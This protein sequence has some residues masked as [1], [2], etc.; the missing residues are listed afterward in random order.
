MKKI[1]TGLCLIALGGCY[2]I[3]RT[4]PADSYLVDT[5][6]GLMCHVTECYYLDLIGSS[7]D[8]LTVAKAYGLPVK[9]YTWSTEQFVELM[10]NPP[11]QLYKAEKLS[12]HEYQLPNNAATTAAFKV[13]DDEDLL[14]YRI[15]GN[16]KGL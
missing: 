2:S 9:T 5:K 12:N 15:G 6:M 3:P 1:I 8:E 11:E 13:L 4:L 7:S 14:I 16:S 10:L